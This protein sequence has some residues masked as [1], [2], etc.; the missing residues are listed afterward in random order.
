MATRKTYG[1][2]RTRTG[3]VLAAA[4]VL[5]AV[6]VWNFL[7]RDRG[8]AGADPGDAAQVALG[9]QVYAAHC[10][11]CHG[12]DLHGQ[13]DWQ[14]RKA[15]GKLPAPPHDETGHTWHHPDQQLFDV[16][17]FGTAAFA[18][19]GYRTDMGAYKDKLS[20]AEIWAVIAYIQSRWPAANRARQDMINAESE[21]QGAY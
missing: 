17:K 20:D 4:F 12:A 10:A 2:N 5:A 6:S 3:I 14:Y 9:A 1:I 7:Y 16:V 21:R 13:P 15:D 11:S 19:I 8:G 18:P